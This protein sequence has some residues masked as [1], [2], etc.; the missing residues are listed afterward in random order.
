[1]PRPDRIA[2]SSAARE[3]PAASA[4]EADAP[5]AASST[6]TELKMV[7]TRATT[8]DPP[9][10]RAMLEIPDACPTWSCETAAVDADDAGPF[11]SP[12]PTESSTSGKDEARVCP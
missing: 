3:T 12:S 10:Y 9:M 8:T 4:S 11:A 1:M 5:A 2:I 6:V 7:A